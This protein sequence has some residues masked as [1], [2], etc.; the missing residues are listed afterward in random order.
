MKI[1]RNAA[2]HDRQKAILRKESLEKLLRK[3]LLEH[4]RNHRTND[5]KGH[6]LENDAHKSESKVAKVELKHAEF[7]PRTRDQICDRMA[8][9]KVTQNRDR[10][11]TNVILRRRQTVDDKGA[12]ENRMNPSSERARRGE[13]RRGRRSLLIAKAN[14][15][16][17]PYFHRWEGVVS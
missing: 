7:N 6:R 15:A 17:R 14:D 1:P 8:N 13:E 4:P 11:F 5:D 9:P 3:Q 16:H 12:S 2:G 10:R